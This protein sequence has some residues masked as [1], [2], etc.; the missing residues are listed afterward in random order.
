MSVI[1]D[2]QLVGTESVEEHLRNA[3]SILWAIQERY[4]DRTDTD[5]LMTAQDVNA[6]DA[7]IV[8][9]LAEYAREHVT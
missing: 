6:V 9:A 5:S 1:R 7:R 2:G 3:R 8:A 4:L